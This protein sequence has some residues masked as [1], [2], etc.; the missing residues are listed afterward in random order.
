VLVVALIMMAVIAISSAAA[1]KGV[2]AQD[3]VGSNQRTNSMALQAAESALRYCEAMLTT[4]KLTKEQNDL[5]PKVQDV[6]A[7]G[8]TVTTDGQSARPKLHWESI[9]NWVGANRKSFPLPKTFV[10]DGSESTYD[11]RPECLIERLNLPLKNKEYTGSPG[12]VP[13][14]FLITARGFSP[15]YAEKDNGT[16]TNGSVVWLQSTIQQ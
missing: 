13:Q 7:T 5:L 1:I 15:D 3:L 11:T 8:Y 14:A 9:D 6:V 10:F 12:Y 2:T 16:P 4:A